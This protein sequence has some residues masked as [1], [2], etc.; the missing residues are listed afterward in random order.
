VGDGL[1]GHGTKNERTG[2]VIGSIVCA[3]ESS[4]ADSESFSMASAKFSATSREHAL[5][6][7]TFLGCMR[8]HMYQLHDNGDRDVKIYCLICWS[9]CSLRRMVA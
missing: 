1:A 9:V 8:S 2:S 3:V 5:R 7:A 6:D 4:E